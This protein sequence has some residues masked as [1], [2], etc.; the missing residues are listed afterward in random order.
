MNY[1]FL[2]W[3]SK[4]KKMIIV[5]SFLKGESKTV[6]FTQSLHDLYI[7]NVQDV[8]WS[9][10]HDLVHERFED[11]KKWLKLCLPEGQT[12]MIWSRD[13]QRSLLWEHYY[14]ETQQNLVH[15]SELNLYIL[16]HPSE[17]QWSFLTNFTVICVIKESITNSFIMSGSSKCNEP[18]SILPCVQLSAHFCQQNNLGDSI[19]LNQFA[20]HMAL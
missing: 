11:G 14:V 6:N 18:Y 10:I 17:F 3:I 12:R 13:S 20:E 1:F 7:P 15:L 5:F 19:T 4:N 2:K 16:S 8:Q 9:W